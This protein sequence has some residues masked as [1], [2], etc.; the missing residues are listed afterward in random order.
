M[1]AD[2]VGAPVTPQQWDY[3]HDMGGALRKSLENVTAVFAP[4][5]IGHS[6]LTKKD[7][8]NIKIDDISFPDA[9]R[10]WEQASIKDKKMLRKSSDNRKKKKKLNNHKKKQHQDLTL[11]EREQRRKERRRQERKNLTPEQREQRRLERRERRRQE[12]LKLKM[13]QQKQTTTTIPRAERSPRPQDLNSISSS[14]NLLPKII[15]NEPTLNHNRQHHR[16]KNHNA[17]FEQFQTKRNQHNPKNNNKQ[18]RECRHKGGGKCRNNQSHNNNNNNNNRNKLIR[19][20][21]Q[22]IEIKEP[23]KCSIRLLERCSWPQCNKSCP[24]ITNP[25]TGEEMK[26]LELLSSFG[27]DMDGVAA[28][29]G[30]DIQT[31]NNMEHYELLSMLTQTPNS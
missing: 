27:L 2:S 31:L 13:D 18:H 5:C 19:Y 16:R 1:R 21:N 17:T 8:L 15:E 11:E 23:T 25:V 28:A 9:L 24:T 22:L 29:L 6:V 3:I 26:I 20:N 7:W 14:K 12:R 30:V 4:S 10:C